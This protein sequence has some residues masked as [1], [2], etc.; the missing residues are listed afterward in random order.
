MSS[1]ES[2]ESVLVD[3]RAVFSEHEIAEIVRRVQFGETR[4]PFS[5]VFVRR[6]VAS[7]VAKIVE[8][9]YHAN[10]RP[11]QPVLSGPDA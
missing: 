9:E 1:G 3:M 5:A 11:K 2:V 7:D 8:G 10:A 6:Q 4:C